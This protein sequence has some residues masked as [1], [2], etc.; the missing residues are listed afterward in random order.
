M[1]ENEEEKTRFKKITAILMISSLWAV[2][3][4]AMVFVAVI[5]TGAGLSFGFNKT[6]MILENFDEILYG[7][8]LVICE[9]VCLIIGL[10]AIIWAIYIKF[11][12][13]PQLI[14][15]K[16]ELDEESKLKVEKRITYI[17]NGYKILLKYG[18]ILLALTG[19]IR[20]LKLTMS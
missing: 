12:K 3:I 1:E 18:A 2:V 17:N 15:E 19:L 6:E 7:I 10:S 9:I 5:S 8:L 20:L 4:E 13:N 16:E 11:Y 14:K